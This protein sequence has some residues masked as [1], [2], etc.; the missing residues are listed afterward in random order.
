MDRFAFGGGAFN[1]NGAS[2][3]ATSVNG[4]VGPGAGT[5]SSGFYSN[6]QTGLGGN[7]IIGAPSQPLFP[8]A[9]GGAFPIQTPAGSGFLSS[10]AS[11]PY[12]LL[13]DLNFGGA[14]GNP[15]FQT[16][17]TPNIYM[18]GNGGNGGGGGGF[19]NTGILSGSTIVAGDGGMC[20]G[21]GAVVSN[22][23]VSVAK[24]GNG[25]FFAGVGSYAG[26]AAAVTFAGAGDGGNG[27]GGG[28][29]TVNN[30]TVRLSGAGGAGAVI[31][32]WTDGY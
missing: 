31:L 20:G 32:F 11:N 22:T 7:G 14:G 1:I 13:V 9:G 15:Y 28:G 24:A 27:G 3:F 4:L 8:T 5:A 17:T 23:N 29:L 26:L 18:A 6:A 16:T 21:G 30:G 19:L 2:I 12:L 10:N 25:G